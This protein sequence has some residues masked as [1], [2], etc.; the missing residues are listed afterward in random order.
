MSTKNKV[1]NTSNK[2]T[3]AN[4]RFEIAC[5]LVKT[6]K[7]LVKNISDDE[8]GKLYGL[9]KQSLIG[10]CNVTEPNK[11]TNYKEYSKWK[12]WKKCGGLSK[13]ESMNEY[14][15]FVLD[16]HDKYVNK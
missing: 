14:A 8:L 5:R 2:L 11:L 9:Y 15:D 3:D 10:D 1:S 13:L 16:M 7:P 6:N 4:E 12:Y